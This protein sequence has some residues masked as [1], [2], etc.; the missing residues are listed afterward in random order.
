MNY[1][2]FVALL[3]MMGFVRT[4]GAHGASQFFIMSEGT[5]LYY[6]V[7]IYSNPKAGLAIQFQDHK[8][9]QPSTERTYD[10]GNPYELMAAHIKEVIYG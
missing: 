8:N 5:E 2:D 4:H 6:V 10:D 3:L 1:E 9:N 7:K